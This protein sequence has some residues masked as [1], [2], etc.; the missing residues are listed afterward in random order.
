MV[1]GEAPG[2]NESRTGK[3]FTGRSGQLLRGELAKA[4]LTEPFITNVV[5][6]RPPDNRAP[7]P[8]EIKAC[9]KYLDYEIERIKP[10]YIVTVGSTPAKAILKKSKITQ[11]RGRMVPVPGQPGIVGMP[12]FHPAYALRDPS[13]LTFIT[14]DFERLKRHSQGETDDGSEDIVWKVVDES[15]EDEFISEFACSEEFAFDIECN[16]LF[17]YNDTGLITC[18]N[19]ALPKTSWVIPAH[20]VSPETGATVNKKRWRWFKQVVK[21]LV[22]W[23]QAKRIWAAGQN[24]KFDNIWLKQKVGVAFHL[25]FDTMLAH[26]TIDENQPHDLKYLARSYLDV[27]DYDLTTKE[28]QGYCDPQKLYLYNARDGAYTLRIARILRRI[29]R[30]D[31]SMSRLFHKLTMPSSRV[32]ESVEAR[33]IPLDLDT[34]AEIERETRKKRD[35][36]KKALDAEVWKVRKARPGKPAKNVNW[37][38]PKQVAPFLYQECGLKSSVKTGTGADSTGE[39]ALADLRGKHPVVDRLIEFRELEK[40][41]GTY[42]EGWKEFIIGGRLHLGYKIHG[43]V[44]GR[45]S[46]RLHQIPRDGRI[47]NIATGYT[48]SRGRRWVFAQGDISQAELRIAGHLSGD[49]EL[50][51]AYR[52]GIDVHWATLLFM[53]GTGNSKE[54][55]EPAFETAAKIAGVSKGKLALGEAIEIM[56]KAGHDA[57]IAL[58]KTWKEARKKAKAVNFGFIYGMFERKFIETAKLKYGWEPT[59][60]EASSIRDAYFELYAGLVTWH[61]RVKKLLAIDGYVVSLSGRKRRL[62]GIHSSDKKLQ[63]EAERQAINSPVQGFIGDYKAM[64]MVEI[65]D[66]IDHDEAVIVG[67][68][69]DALLFLIREDAVASVGPKIKA[70]M[71]NPRLLKDFKVE[72][73]I[74]MESDLELGNWGKGT[75]LGKWLQERKVA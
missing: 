54:Y 65:E 16:Q 50:I 28:K 20:D 71:K 24:A 59:F 15:N 74:P 30:A 29:I 72:L 22:R 51:T 14:Q 23:Q 61:K 38:S 39:A 43:T 33:G 21:T 42:L 44:T 13:K 47:R 40:F 1:V 19:V 48:D 3:P 53:I 10:K 31:L 41:L 11:D 34:Y 49:I 6:C 18:L 5:R 56:R 27:E 32:L 17:P 8:D 60:D 26:Y 67:E 55:L 37:N 2:E 46:S 70:I 57:C 36:A 63:M 35:E 73:S 52:R 7:K 66:T 68:H 45:F 4:R 75:E 9:R 58:N 12:T 69:H 64:C 62:P 25:D